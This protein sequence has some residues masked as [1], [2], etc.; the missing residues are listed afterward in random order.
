MD[1]SIKSILL[2]DDNENDIEL[3]IEALAENNLA[4]EV[5]IAKDGEEALDYLYKRGKFTDRKDGNPTVVFLDIKM[6]KLNGIEVLQIMRQDPQFKLIPVV[7]LTSSKEEQ[8]LVRSYDLG[9]NAYV[10]KPVNFSKFIEVVRV[11]GIF[12]AVINEPPITIPSKS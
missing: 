12:W 2:V 11:L 8:D 6:P 7:M 10:V 1:I 5:A 9:I 3:T 4:N